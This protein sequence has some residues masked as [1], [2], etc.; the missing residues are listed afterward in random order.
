[1][2]LTGLA[3]DRDVREA[4]FLPHALRVALRV[5]ALVD[6]DR[7]VAKPAPARERDLVGEVMAEAALLRVVRAFGAD[8][9][10]LRHRPRAVA[11]RVPGR[12]RGRRR[13]AAAYCA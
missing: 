2:P 8:E 4:S 11:G 10:E 7:T 5:H 9:L 3:H 12:V 1:M 6:D 13:R